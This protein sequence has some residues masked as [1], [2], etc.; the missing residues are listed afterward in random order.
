[1][2]YSTTHNKYFLLLQSRA[3]LDP[4]DSRRLTMYYKYVLSADNMSQLPF[5]SSGEGRGGAKQHMF[6]LVFYSPVHTLLKTIRVD[7]SVSLS[8]LSTVFA[9][10]RGWR[11][12]FLPELVSQREDGFSEVAKLSVSDTLPQKRQH[13]APREIKRMSGV[14]EGRMHI[15]SHSN[16]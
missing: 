7:S 9:S 14:W 6:Q 10:V 15:N 12:T 8:S 5:S 16:Y 2:S 3:S 11:V 13:P 4:A 1:M